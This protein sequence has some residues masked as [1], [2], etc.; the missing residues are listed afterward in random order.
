M[1]VVVCTRCTQG[2]ALSGVSDFNSDHETFKITR[3]K[4][5]PIKTS[6]VIVSYYGYEM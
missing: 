5:S 6:L 3:T 2:K 4:I 1:I